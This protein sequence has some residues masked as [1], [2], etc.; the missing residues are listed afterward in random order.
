MDIKKGRKNKAIMGSIMWLKYMQNLSTQIE[1]STTCGRGVN[2]NNKY[3][4][5]DNI[6]TY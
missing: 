4:N 3:F 5:L 6:L 2:G 1:N